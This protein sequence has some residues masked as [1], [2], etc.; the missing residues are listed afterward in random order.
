MLLQFVELGLR[1][2][3]ELKD[4]GVDGRQLVLLGGYTSDRHDLGRVVAQHRR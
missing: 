4:A 1:K 3:T 2:D